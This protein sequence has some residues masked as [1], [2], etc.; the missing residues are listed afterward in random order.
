MCVQRAHSPVCAVAPLLS[1]RCD[2]QNLMN[3]E[4][5]VERNILAFSRLLLLLEDA[6]YIRGFLL[7]QG[8]DHNRTGDP[9]PM[10]ATLERHVAEEMKEKRKKWNHHSSEIVVEGVSILRS[11][12]RPS[13]NWLIF[14]ATTTANGIGLCDCS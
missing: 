6:G 14:C 12:S 10:D 7:D 13:S 3:P 9:A 8:I 4:K 1:I 5:E 11:S 2:S